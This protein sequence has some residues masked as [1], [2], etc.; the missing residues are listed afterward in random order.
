MKIHDFLERVEFH[1]KPN[2]K[3]WLDVSSSHFSLTQDSTEHY[4]AIRRIFRHA[5]EVFLESGRHLVFV[6]TGHYFTNSQGEKI[7]IFLL[8]VHLDVQSKEKSISWSRLNDTFILNPELNQG[9]AEL[10]KAEI[11]TW[12]EQTHL[13]YSKD[14]LA[15]YFDLSHNAYIHRDLQTIKRE[16]WSSSALDSL[17]NDAIFHNQN[18]HNTPDFLSL[19]HSLAMDNSQAKAIQKAREGSCV[20]VGPPGTGK[21]QTIINLAIQEVLDG[22]KVAII[23]Q[24]KAALDVILQR[25][26]HLSLDS[27]HLNLVDEQAN[28][29]LFS[30]T[31]ESIEFYLSDRTKESI[32]TFNL[33]YF[34]HC[35]RTIADYFEARDKKAHMKNSTRKSDLSSAFQHPIFDFIYP[36]AKLLKIEPTDLLMRWRELHQILNNQPI[37]S[38]YNLEFIKSLEQPLRLLSTINLV[39]LRKLLKKKKIN[40]AL[41]ALELKKKSTLLTKPKESMLEIVGEERLIYYHDYLM[42]ANLWTKIYNPKAKEIALDISKIY[43][44][45]NAKKIWDRIALVREALDSLAWRKQMDKIQIEENTIRNEN[46]GE[47]ASESL[48]YIQNKI[49]SRLP[50]WLFV[51]EHFILNAAFDLM[52]WKILIS[53]VK[54]IL[55]FNPELANSPIKDIISRDFSENLILPKIDW[56]KYCCMDFENYHAWMVYKNASYNESITNRVLKNYSAREIVTMSNF[57]RKHYAEYVSYS[58]KHEMQKRETEKR[59][60]FSSILNSRKTEPKE[61]RD[62]WKK[63]IQFIQKKWSKKRNKP[64]L[65]QWLK[66]VDIDFLLWLKPLTIA[67]LDKFSQYLPLESE[68]YDTII[69]DEASQV[70]LRDSIPALLRAKKL[71]VVGDSQQLT[72]SRFFKYQNYSIED[73]HESLLELAEEKMESNIL[74]GH[75]RSRYRELIHFSNFYFYQNNLSV[76]SPSSDF[77][78]ERIYL[79]NSIYHQRKNKEEAIKIVAALTDVLLKF[80]TTKSV[81]IIS[82][83]LQQKDMILNVLDEVLITNRKLQDAIQKWEASHEPFFVKSIEQVQGDERDIILISTGYAKNINGQLY[84]FFGPILKFKGE[85]RLN[86]LMSR[87]REKIIWVTSLLSSDLHT[88]SSSSIG[89][90]R[91]QQL[92]AYM[93]NPITSSTISRKKTRNYWDYLTGFIYN[94]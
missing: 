12:L 21:S 23:S 9:Q 5:K 33:S 15:L 3:K 28:V 16:K 36:H 68:L 76:R 84:H 49:K 13:S 31:E 82:F 1:T 79:S 43:L 89:L 62:K 69:I 35:V 38:G 51:Q 57:V 77:A 66:T 27:L 19:T 41:K 83:S 48:I 25:L 71:I 14:T 87:A 91:F 26:H 81:G 53:N 45:W 29:N 75:Y 37:L 73:P 72:P 11:E 85:N 64:S 6:S 30:S 63:S 24:K 46:L 88:S 70:E 10:S 8:P 78:I 60:E 32:E 55:N 92:L 86:V 40:P 90:L 4:G 93:E 58:L 59:N 65:F 7:P 67:T 44:K 20:I 47:V 94:K 42:S 50:V 54:E 80:G 34:K 61:R 2:F 74:W 17:W 22:K 56:E 39:E 52:Y 18:N